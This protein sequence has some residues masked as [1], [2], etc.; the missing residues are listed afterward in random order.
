M[1]CGMRTRLTRPDF[2]S[3]ASTNT[4]FSPILTGSDTK[5]NTS[6]YNSPDCFDRNLGALSFH[7]R[8]P[9]GFA[10]GAPRAVLRRGNGHRTGYSSCHVPVGCGPPFRAKQVC[11]VR[12][13]LPV[14]AGCLLGRCVLNRGPVSPDYCEPI[15]Q[16]LSKLFVF[17]D[18][19]YQGLLLVSLAA[20]ILLLNNEQAIGRLGTCLL[21]RQ[22]RDRFF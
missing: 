22:G 7:R 11:T 6:P 3:S 17:L 12:M 1:V 19:G 5:S 16:P 21:W 10:R 2:R 4:R 20:S 18:L 13:F 8:C 14:W 15:S 9:V